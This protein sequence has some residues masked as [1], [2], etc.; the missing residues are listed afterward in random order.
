[1]ESKKHTDMVRRLWSCVGFSFG[2]S[3]AQGKEGV[4]FGLSESLVDDPTPGFAL[5]LEELQS[6][7]V[8]LKEKME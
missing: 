6:I 7:L 5:L 1:M 8:G 4:D 3:Y 2:G